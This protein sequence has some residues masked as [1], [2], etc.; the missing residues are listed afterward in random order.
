MVMKA[1]AGTGG[2][3]VEGLFAGYGKRE[4]LFDVKLHVDPGAVVGVVG[5][6]GAGKT[7]LLKS[8][9]RSIPID[10]G[11]IR[12][13]VHDL[14]KKSSPFVVQKGISFTPAS[15][16]I[17]RDLTVLENLELGAFSLKKRST[18][19]ERLDEVVQVFP[20]L[21]DRLK[22]TAGRFSGGQQRQLSIAMALMTNPRL[23]LLDEP[24]LGI[25][26]SVVQK[27]F[28][29]IRDLSRERNSS[30][31]VVEQNVKAMTK[32]ADRIYVLRNGQVVL[33]ESRE[34]ALARTDWWSLF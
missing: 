25:S 33:E 8:I 6:N 27:T 1:E 30:V 18:Y 34:Q 11:I 14:T 9:F 26:P 23:M 32:I 2:L 12:F 24:S 22:E 21:S 5:H 31:L 15:L 13:D 20:I 28:Q 16:P 4:V 3:F 17:F 29:V 10:R 7:T 19:R